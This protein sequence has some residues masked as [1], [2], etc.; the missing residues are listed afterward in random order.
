MDTDPLEAVESMLDARTPFCR[1]EDWIERQ[2][3]LGRDAKSALWLLA[4][5]EIDRAERRQVVNEL[6]AG[7]A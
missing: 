1:I 6:L 7:I 4:W 5:S 2:L 3:D